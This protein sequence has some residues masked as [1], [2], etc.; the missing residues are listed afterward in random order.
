MIYAPVEPRHEALLRRVVEE[1]VIPWLNSFADADGFILSA[2]EFDP[3]Q[4]KNSETQIEMVY[5]PE[6][7][8]RLL[9][10]AA[11]GNGDDGG[12]MYLIIHAERDSTIRFT[13]NRVTAPAPWLGKEPDTHT[14]EQ[15]VTD[16]LDT[17]SLDLVVQ[18]FDTQFSVVYDRTAEE[19]R[20][21]SG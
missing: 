4:D 15:T 12:P 8:D 14:Y 21:A 3:K 20:T 17:Y 19:N 18:E 1:K 2:A 9:M 7:D 16:W 6:G 11:A 10:Y 13:G 5:E